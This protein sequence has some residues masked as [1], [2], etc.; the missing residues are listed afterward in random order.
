MTLQGCIK[1]KKESDQLKLKSKDGKYRL[2]DVWMSEGFTE[3]VEFAILTN[4]IYKEWSGM[5]ASRYK[6]FKG[7]IKES[8]RD[9]MCQILKQ[10]LLILVKSQLENQL[11][12]KKPICLEQNKKIAKID[13]HTAKVTKDYL[14][15]QLGKKVIKS[16]N[17][18]N[19]EYLDEKQIENK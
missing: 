17:K 8:L 19:Y 7:L 14:E 16:E 18:L 13:G 5:T 15:K 10:L 9:N 1:R 2:T 6:E 4:E 11:K 3:D 12:K